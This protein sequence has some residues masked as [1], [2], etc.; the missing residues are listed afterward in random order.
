M[1]LL[2]SARKPLAVLPPTRAVVEE[3]LKA[4]DS[5]L[6]ARGVFAERVIAARSVLAARRVFVERSP[7]G[8][9]LSR[10]PLLVI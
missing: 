8:R 4:A 1:V 5:V 10:F 3:R 9:P 2:K 7:A 6:T